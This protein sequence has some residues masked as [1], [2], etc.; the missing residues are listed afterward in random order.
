ALERYHK[1]DYRSASRYLLSELS[2]GD[3][4]VSLAVDLPLRNYY[5]RAPLRGRAPV[6]WQDMGRLVNWRGRIALKGQGP[7]SYEEKLLAAWEPGRR[8]FVFL[9]REWV[10]D[11]GG[12]LERDLRRRGDLVAE[13][14][15]P[16]TRV[17]V[18]ERRG[19]GNGRGGAREANREQAR[20]AGAERPPEETRG[21]GGEP[22]PAEAESAASR[23]PQ[24]RS[25]G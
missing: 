16:G 18:L 1:E 11:P 14:S 15:W 13:A 19:S 2:P 4:F 24:R 25:S 3:A 9:A 22:S 21:P 5:M 6:P 23:P 20:P 7:D 12:V 17:L 10:T 8:L